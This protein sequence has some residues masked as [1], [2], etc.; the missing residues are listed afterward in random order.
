MD[1]P[2]KIGWIGRA[3]RTGA[4]LALV[5]FAT[6]GGDLSWNLD[7]LDVVLG[8]G[9]FP[10]V[11]LSAGLVAGRYAAGPLRYTGPVAIALNCV[12]IV[13]LLVNPYTGGGA[14]LFYGMS[15][16][17]A[18]WR[19]QSDCEATVLSNWLLHR[20]DQFGCP[21]FTPIDV[22]ESRLL[23]RSS[24]VGGGVRGNES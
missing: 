19:G 15:L 17:V 6:F 2:Q 11:T 8:L 10:A 22:A 12:V 14:E 5:Y 18:A 13:V 9:V 16:L 23:G 24:R 7:W 4:G 20:D 3:S 21:I 1:M